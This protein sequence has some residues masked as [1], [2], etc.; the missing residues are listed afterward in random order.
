MFVISYAIHVYIYEGVLFYKKKY[1]PVHVFNI[2]TII[3]VI[4]GQ[5]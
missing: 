3:Y 5:M 1:G 4:K 2:S